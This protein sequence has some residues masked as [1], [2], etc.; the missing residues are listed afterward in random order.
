MRD[1]TFTIL[2]VSALFKACIKYRKSFSLHSTVVTADFS[3]H[4]SFIATINNIT[5]EFPSFPLL[6]E[7]ERIDESMFCDVVHMK[8]KNCVRDSKETIC[9]CIHRLKVKLNANVEFVAL[10][11]LD[12]IP[13]PLHLHGHKFHVLDSGILNETL[14]GN[15]E[16]YVTRDNAKRPPYKDTCILP[17]PGFVRFRFRA[18]NPGFWLFHCHYDWHMPIGIGSFITTDF[19]IKLLSF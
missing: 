15:Y 19:V 16:D 11:T 1:E 2:F 3:K 4:V 5:F 10:N 13:H 12:K 6:S 18:S 17:F 9:K 7:P 14:N 8:R